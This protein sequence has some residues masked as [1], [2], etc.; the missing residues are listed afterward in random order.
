[1]G[2]GL[3]CG[4]DFRANPLRPILTAHRIGHRPASSAILSRGMTCGTIRMSEAQKIVL[5]NDYRRALM[6]CALPLYE[7]GEN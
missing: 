6:T 3:I 5:G 2:V 1:M 4:A 7:G